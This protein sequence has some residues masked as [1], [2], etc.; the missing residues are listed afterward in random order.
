MKPQRMIKEFAHDFFF[1]EKQ[2]K[3][4]LILVFSI[5]SVPEKSFF[6]ILF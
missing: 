6:I 2:T 1:E 4:L 3:I 5:H